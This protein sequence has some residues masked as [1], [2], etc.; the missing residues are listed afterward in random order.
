MEEFNLLKKHLV[1]KS[2]IIL[3]ANHV[4]DILI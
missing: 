3:E 2:Y 4:F 1:A